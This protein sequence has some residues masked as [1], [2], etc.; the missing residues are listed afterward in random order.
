MFVKDNIKKSG[1]KTYSTTLLVQG[2]RENGK[3]RHKTLA[4]MS[5]WPKNIVDEIR[6]IVKGGKV[7]FF[8]NEI[9]TEQGKAFGALYALYEITKRLGIEKTFGN[10][11]NA[12][13]CLAMILGRILNQGSRLSLVSWQ[14]DQSIKEVLETHR[15]NEDQLYSAMDWLDKNNLELEKKIFKSRYKDK[16]PTF[17]LYDVTSS[18]FEGDQ[19]EL[20]RY[21]YN[22]DGKKGKKQIVIGL[23]ADAEGMPIAGRVFEGNTNDQK[24]VETQIELLAKEFGVKSLVFVGDRGMIKR[25]QQKQITS[26]DDWY[27]ITAITKPEI[28]KMLNE[29]R[30]QMEL[31]TEELGVIEEYGIRYILRRNPIRQSEIRKNREDIF[32]SFK[33]AVEKKNAY[34]ISHRGSKTQTHIKL[35]KSWITKRKLAECLEIKESKR[36]IS[37]EINKNALSE[38][39]KLDGCYIIKTNVPPKTATVREIHDRYKDLK[40]VENNFRDLKTF[41]LEVR[42]IFHRKATRTRGLVYIAVYALMI[43]KYLEKETQELNLTTQHKINTLDKINY[44]IFNIGDQKVKRIPNILSEEQTSILEKLKIKLPTYII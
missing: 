33:D 25:D 18:Y 36:V 19:N 31:F 2:F 15:F 34:L 37:F 28:E 24:T 26:H 30:I 39:E 23:L 12:K 44:T 17:Y 14:N 7:N 1:N 38:K 11:R 22:R 29:K 6:K 21:G 40:H 13:L 16:T 8:Q 42:P 35:L 4:N 5:Y 43:I 10:S 32:K 3:V 9:N 41:I 20:A 27:F